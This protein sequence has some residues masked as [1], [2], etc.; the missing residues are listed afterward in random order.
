MT[1]AATSLALRLQH[2]TSDDDARA[3]LLA[4][5]NDGAAPD[6]IRTAFDEWTAMRAAAVTTITTG[7][8]A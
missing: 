6:E 1:P 2:T 7:E 4:A 8:S 5:L 3:L